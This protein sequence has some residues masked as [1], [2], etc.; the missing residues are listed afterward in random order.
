MT[1][2]LH[3]TE[4]GE[5]G[6]RIVFLHGLF[7]Q[8]RNWMT[9]GQ[10][11]ANEHR[12]TLVDLPHHGRS[13]WS[14]RFDFLEI[15]DQVASLFAA[16]DPV[17]L[18]GHSLGGKVA[19]LIALLHRERVARL[20]VADMAPVAYGNGG[21]FQSYIAAMR[22]LDLGGLRTR[23]DADMALASA[24]PDAGVR[25]FL[26]Q[27]LRRDLGGEGSQ[28]GAWRWQMNLDVLERDLDALSG[29]PTDRLTTTPPYGGPVLWLA[30][31]N[32]GYIT[33]GNAAAMAAWFPKY[34][35]VTIKDAG[36]WLHVDQPEVFTQVL[37]QFAR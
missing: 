2:Q 12:V 25:L 9:I 21:Q 33:D 16:D 37:R 36:H 10:A 4:L 35:K 26:L 29:W 1:F 28:Q 34:R 7:G 3:T 22:S 23:R 31:A 24:I 14:D 19:M 20:C 32:S 18:V 27:N 30:G 8:G 15:A 6:S 11:L 17:V 13:D 5:H